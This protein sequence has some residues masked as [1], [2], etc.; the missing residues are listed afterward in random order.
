MDELTKELLEALKTI[1]S[2]K[3]HNHE[4]NNHHVS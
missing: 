2:W 3:S 1:E 4:R